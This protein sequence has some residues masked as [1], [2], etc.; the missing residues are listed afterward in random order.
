M[1]AKAVDLVLFTPNHTRQTL[2]YVKCADDLQTQG[3]PRTPEVDP[4]AP[5]SSQTLNNTEQGRRG[6][7]D[8]AQGVK[9]LVLSL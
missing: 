2:P 9:G 8:V 1:V 5:W 7:L 3:L 4:P 6:V